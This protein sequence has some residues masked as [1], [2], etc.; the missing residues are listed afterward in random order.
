MWG[1]LMTHL[2]SLCPLLIR[3][4]RCHLGRARRRFDRLLGRALPDRDRTRSYEIARERSNA[5]HQ[6]PWHQHPWHQH[7]PQQLPQQLPCRHHGPL[8][9]RRRGA[10]C[11]T[12]PSATSSS[13]TICTIAIRVDSLIGKPVAFARAISSWT[14]SHVLMRVPSRVRALPAARKAMARAS[15][16]CRVRTTRAQG[17]WKAMEGHGRPWQAM[18][19]HGRLGHG[20]AWMEGRRPWKATEGHGRPFEREGVRSGGSTHLACD[21]LVGA[22]RRPGRDH[23]A[24]LGQLSY[25]TRGLEGRRSER[26]KHRVSRGLEARRGHEARMLVEARRSGVC[27][28]LETRVPSTI[29]IRA[30]SSVSW[31]CRSCRRT[32]SRSLSRCSLR[33]ARASGSAPT[34]DRR[35][36]R[37]L[38]EPW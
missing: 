10:R 23:S 30:S 24:L 37:E 28:G 25:G 5:R 26:G 13:R 9:S 35:R 4:L 27:R 20:W 15:Q 2:L 14:L 12:V 16:S 36:V 11:R 31:E 22:L 19:G 33:S 1:D 17:S 8:G 18:E 3:P 32:E 29:A 7:L 21:R 34:T 6:H 38:G